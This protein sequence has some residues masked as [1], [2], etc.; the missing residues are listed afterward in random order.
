MELHYLQDLYL[1]REN[2][3][4]RFPNYDCQDKD[5]LKNDYI[6]AKNKFEIPVFSQFFC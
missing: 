6:K 1:S 3:F 2:K 4:N 5:S